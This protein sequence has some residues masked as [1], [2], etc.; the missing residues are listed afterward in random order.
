MMLP[1]RELKNRN[2]GSMTCINPSPSKKM[3]ASGQRSGPQIASTAN[4][5]IQTM[6]C[7]RTICQK[8]LRCSTLPSYRLSCV[9]RKCLLDW[10]KEYL[11]LRTD[12]DCDTMVSQQS[13]AAKLHGKSNI[14]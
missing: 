2:F 4:N 8:R 12:Y 9:D 3:V 1:R 6:S 11:V 7:G 13:I 5:A 10:W 14:P